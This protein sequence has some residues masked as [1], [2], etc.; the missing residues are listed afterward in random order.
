MIVTAVLEAERGRYEWG[1]RDCCTT[2]VALCEALL[3]RH[4]DDLRKSMQRFHIHSREPSAIHAAEAAYG[5]V[6]MAYYHMLRHIE[7]IDVLSERTGVVPGDIVWLEGGVSLSGGALS[8]DAHG[9]SVIGFNGD[10][11]ALYV[12]SPRGLRAAW[13]QEAPRRVFRCRR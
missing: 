12:W 1:V 13:S 2:T 7:G 8:A 5:S 4:L 10:D 9:A 3:G 11:A 6:G